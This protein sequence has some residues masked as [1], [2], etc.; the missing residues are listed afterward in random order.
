MQERVAVMVSFTSKHE[1]VTP[2][3]PKT[4]TEKAWE[5]LLD[6]GAFFRDFF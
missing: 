6:K 4:N 3:R 2:I 5:E 1:K